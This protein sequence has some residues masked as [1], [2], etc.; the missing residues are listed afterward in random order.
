M[1]TGSSLA[2]LFRTEV[3]NVF[4]YFVLRC[5]SRQLAEDLTSQTFMA[6]SEHF[7]SG[8]GVEVTPAWLQTVA[9]RRLIDHWRSSGAQKRRFDRL[10]ALRSEHGQQPPPDPHADV[11]EALDALPER[12]RAVLVLR[13]LEEFSVGEV[14]KALEITYKAAESLLGRARLS[15]I[16]AYE[17]VKSD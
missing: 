14:A 9:S 16:V 13:Y 15:F 6:A 17:E 4:G 7:A 1:H 11:L 5:G 2:E 3:S 10:V 8:R 12:Q